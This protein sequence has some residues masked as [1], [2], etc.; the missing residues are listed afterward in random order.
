MDYKKDNMPAQSEKLDYNNNNIST[1][2]EKGTG[3]K[4]ARGS[5]CGMPSFSSSGFG[6]FPPLL[7]AWWP[8]L[9]FLVRNFCIV[10]E[11]KARQNEALHFAKSFQTRLNSRNSRLMK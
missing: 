1:N 10:T 8:P 2:M 4:G 11:S 9:L 7:F 3:N 6:F 5:R